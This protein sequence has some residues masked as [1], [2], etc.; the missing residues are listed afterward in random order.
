MPPF[1]AIPF[2]ASPWP[3][4]LGKR[5]WVAVLGWLACLCLQLTSLHAVVLWTD[6]DVTLVHDTKQGRDILSGAVKRDETANDTLYFKFHVD[7]LSDMD[8][9]EYFAAFE[10]FDGDTERLGIGNSLKAWAYSAF[11]HSAETGETNN[12]DGYID[13]HSL[14]RERP[15]DGA[16]GS[17]QYPRHGVGVTIVFKVQYVP[18]EDDLVT[19]W[20]NPDLG[21]GANEAYQPDGLTTRFIANCKFDEIRLRHGG[22]GGGWSFSDLAIATSFSDF[23]DVSSSW[24]G[25]TAGGPGGVRAFNFQSW[26]KEQGL[27]QAPVRALLQTR[28]GYLWMGGDDGLARFDGLR[29]VPFGLAEG[30]K[31]GVV[32][33]LLEDFQGALWIGSAQDGLSCWQNNQIKTFKVADG[34]PADE[35]SAL[36][37]DRAGRLWIGTSGGLVCWPD[38]RPGATNARPFFSDHAITALREYQPGQIWIGVK[39]VGVFQF[40]DGQMT[41]VVAAGFEALL[42]QSHCFF[43]DSTGKMLVSAGDDSLLV[44]DAEQ[45]HRYQVPRNLAKSYVNALTEE[46]DGTL[47]AGCAQGG[48]LQFRDGKFSGSPTGVGL[49]GSIIESLLSDRE[50]RLWVGTDTALNRIRHKSLFALSQGE[51][52]GYGAAKSLAEVRPGVLWAA[53]PNDGLY[54][55]DGKSF[56]RLPA[57]GLSAHDSQIT[58]LL[59]TH[60]GFCWVATDKNLFLYKDPIAAV[61]ETRM[62]KNT[63]PGII[64]LAEGQNE[65]LWLGTQGGKLWHLHAGQWS[66]ET[67]L[68]QTNPVTAII[69]QANGDLWLGTAGGGL[70]RLPGESTNQ[71][72]VPISGLSSAVIETL[73]QDRQ[74]TLWIGTANQGMCR[75]R[76]GRID[77]FTPGQGLPTHVSQILEDDAGRLW[78][79][80]KAGIACVNIQRLDDLAAGKITTIYP[81]MF[82]PAEGM[83]AEECT[84][85]FFPAGLK[86]HSGLL[87][88]STTKG[89]VVIDP[90]VLP[91]ANRSPNT[92]LEEVLVDGIPDPT[93]HGS[94]PR[95]AH[96]VG[97]A[98]NAL[99][100]VETLRITPGHHRVEFRYTGLNFDAPGQIRFRYRLDGLDND[101]SDAGTRRTAFYGYLPPGDYSFHVAACNS[102]GVWTLSTADLRVIVLRHFWQSWWFIAATGL[103][104]LSLVI[105]AVRVVEKRRLNRRLKLLEQERALERERT[106]I[107]Q[108]L[109]D[110]MGAKLC[111]ISFLSEHT[112]RGPLLPGELKDQ[113]T[114]ISDASRELLHSLDEIVWAVNPQNDTLEHVASYIGQYAQDYFQ[115]TGLH[116]EL[117]IPRQLPAHPI[118]SQMRHHIF[119][120]THEAL[121]NILKHSGATQA[122]ITMTYDGAALNLSITDNGRGFDPVTT[123]AGLPPGVSGDGLS[124]MKKRL[125]DMGGNCVIESAPGQGTVVHFVIPLNFSAKPR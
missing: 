101:W 92:V 48:L 111:R 49:N 43:R 86:T 7:P 94:T 81:Q 124:N 114:S 54:R 74:G 66:E 104:F 105:V 55:W 91:I 84:S 121:T 28:D 109:H 108:D 106:R 36:A 5:K 72:A 119:L 73:Y 78:L 15:N 62:I 31:F 113:I 100:Q 30:I 116:C 51:G 20:L 68:S 103:S 3:E 33:A 1:L 29:F 107:A 45:W 90:S 18:G 2:A 67:R 47:W 34:L 115:V 76:N 58:S 52:L 37:Q 61:D 44:W 64:A 122:K 80:G 56:G 99:D 70:Y 16:A 40:S 65:S 120:A 32:T 110:E 60:D 79:G 93:L 50:G 53:K 41:P 8:T 112:R 39:G 38:G 23:V 46:L 26:Q 71:S 88:F 6:P 82:G 17:F 35:V 69:T 10:L 89:V 123:G 117:D 85:G 4:S 11:F 125:A 98:T 97:L 22:K 63:K 57:R 13:L 9:E 59:L 77:N 21:P 27:P 19:V 96:P 83:L 12:L 102:D 42:K 75:W 25:L 95:P 24:P 118:S 87:W 14:K